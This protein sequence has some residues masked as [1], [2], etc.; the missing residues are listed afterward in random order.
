M[1][2]EERISEISMIFSKTTEEMRSYAKSNPVNISARIK[3]LK[4]LERD[5]YRNFPKYSICFSVD[6]IYGREIEHF[7]YMG[8]MSDEELTVWLEA[9]FPGVDRSEF[10]RPEGALGLDRHFMKAVGWEERSLFAG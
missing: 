3:E 2:M 4:G 10:I 6:I 5:F 8:N 1:T 7:S 9:F